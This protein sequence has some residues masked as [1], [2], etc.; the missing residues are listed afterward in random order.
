MNLFESLFLTGLII[1]PWNEHRHNYRTQ[2]SFFDIIVPMIRTLCHASKYREKARYKIWRRFNSYHHFLNLYYISKCWILWFCTP[3]VRNNLNEP[4]LIREHSFEG[5][6]RP[7]TSDGPD[8][9][10]L[11]MHLDWWNNLPPCNKCC[12]LKK[13]T[14]W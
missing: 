4:F 3:F 10:Y 7:N 14:H 9:M 5:D 13:K 8:T 2:S 12:T 6:T 11:S 1:R